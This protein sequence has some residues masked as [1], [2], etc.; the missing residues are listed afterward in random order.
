M[1]TFQF[2]MLSLDRE[3]GPS[4]SS[5]HFRGNFSRRVTLVELAQ[6]VSQGDDKPSGKPETSFDYIHFSYQI[7]VLSSCKYNLFLE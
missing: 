7:L 4:K 6:L 1:K 5:V 2:G 3:G